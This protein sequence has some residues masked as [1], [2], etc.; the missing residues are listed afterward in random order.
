MFSSQ[1]RK[2][3]ILLGLS[4]VVLTAIA[5]EAA[6][7]TRSWLRLDHVFF[8]PTPLKALILGFS[9][10]TWVATGYWLDV[11]GKLDF[12]ELRIVLRDSFRQ[13]AYGALA[14][15][16][17][18]YL[19]RMDLSRV[20]L[21]LFAAYTYVLLVLFRFLAGRLIGIIWKEFGALRYVLVV[22]LGARARKLGDRLERPAVRGC[23]L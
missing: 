18:E 3:R 10:L 5:F 4:D 22:G 6:Y 14:L 11:Y 13:S 17:F 9:V 19:L 8:F 20:F 16:V 15:L 2:A 7:Q 1:H 12:G 23:A 21:V